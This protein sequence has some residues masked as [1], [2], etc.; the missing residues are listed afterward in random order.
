MQKSS[1]IAIVIVA[2]VAVGGGAAVLVLNGDS[3]ETAD[4]IVGHT[5]EYRVVG[6][7][8]DKLVSGT[9][10]LNVLSENDTRY[11]IKTVR[12]VYTD[13]SGGTRSVLWN[14]VKTDWVKKTDITSPGKFSKDYKLDTYWGTKDA[15]MYT[16][17]VNGV[18]TT[19]YVAFDKISFETVVEDGDNLYIYMM[20]KTDFMKKDKSYTPPKMKITMAL[21]GTMTVSSN[22]NNKY[23]IGGSVETEL[24]DST[25]VAFKFTIR[26]IMLVEGITFSDDTQT[27]WGYSDSDDS[28]DGIKSG[29][30]NVDTIWGN[31]LTTVYIDTEDGV[32]KT[33]YLYKDLPV[34]MTYSMV[35]QHASMEITQTITEVIV[36]GVY[37]DTIK[38]LDELENA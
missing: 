24:I 38:Q 7:H 5:F 19:S 2:I 8:E 13:T 6:N 20:D 37:I 3:S 28:D 33:T 21:S 29:T 9:Q 18:K 27:M 34:K 36:N 12:E 35:D 22:P 23:S 11:E 15:K 26:E 30:A 32:K 4:T 16:N 1:L 25:G 31:V 17:T 10:T 14:D